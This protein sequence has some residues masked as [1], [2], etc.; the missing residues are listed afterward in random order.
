MSVHID[1]KPRCMPLASIV[2]AVFANLISCR[3]MSNAGQS[4][5]LGASP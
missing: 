4:E 1:A 3:Y 2:A 5:A